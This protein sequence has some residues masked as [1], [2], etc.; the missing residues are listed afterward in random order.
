[1]TNII[2]ANNSGEIQETVN[3]PTELNTDARLKINKKKTELMTNST[4]TYIKLNG[5][6]LDYVAEYIHVGQMISLRDNSGKEIK[7]RVGVKRHR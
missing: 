7:R 1:M 6:A 5:E 4:D 2:S 3:E